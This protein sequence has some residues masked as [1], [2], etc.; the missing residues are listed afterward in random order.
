MP[1]PPK[2]LLDPANYRFEVEVPT[3]FDDI[4]SL[5]HINNVAMAAVFQEG[6]T[7]FDQQLRVGMP[8]L[9]LATLIV[10]AHLEY[11]QQTYYPAPIVVKVAVEQIGGASKTLVQLALQD[12]KPT[13]FCRTVDVNAN[14]GRPSPVPDAWR[15]RLAEFALLRS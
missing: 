14:D 9:R 4:D 10:S 15:A 7:R 11:L 12:G 1:R 13:A 3:R 5:D 8:G 6:R 2:H